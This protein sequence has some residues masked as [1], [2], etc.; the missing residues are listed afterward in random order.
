MQEPWMKKIVEDIKKEFSTIEIKKIGHN[1]YTYNV[2]S[3]Y[4]KDKKELKRYLKNT[5]VR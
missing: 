5:L 4:D 1:Y 2:S 3:V